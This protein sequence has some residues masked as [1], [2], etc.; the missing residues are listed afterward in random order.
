MI[1]ATGATSKGVEYAIDDAYMA[2]RGS[3]DERMI[4]E[5]QRRIAH[6]ILARWAIRQKGEQK[7]A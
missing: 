5:E 1:V 3:E 6:D 2:P 7:S 4:I